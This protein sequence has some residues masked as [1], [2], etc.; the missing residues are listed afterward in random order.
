MAKT[1]VGAFEAKTHFSALLGRVARGES[2]TITRHGEAVA[3]LAP[4]HE[5]PPLSYDEIVARLRAV[6]LKAKPGPGIRQ[7]IDEG[8]RY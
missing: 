1:T 6:K 7:L 2:I 4:V 8:R 5:A 3:R